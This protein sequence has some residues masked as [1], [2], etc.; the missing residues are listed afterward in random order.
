MYKLTTISNLHDF[1][2][3]SWVSIILIFFK[4]VSMNTGSPKTSN[5]AIKLSVYS[6]LIKEMNNFNSPLGK[7]IFGYALDTN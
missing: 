5:L 6:I 2:L 3:K 7:K 1:I 4:L